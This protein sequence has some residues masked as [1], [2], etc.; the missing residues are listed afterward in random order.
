MLKNYQFLTL[1]YQSSTNVLMIKVF[2]KLENFKFIE[3]W[4][5]KIE[6]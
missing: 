4:I 6:N 3:N 1:K 2:K 5:L